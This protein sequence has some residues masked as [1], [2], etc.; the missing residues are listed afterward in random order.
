MSMAADFDK[1]SLVSVT[2]IVFSSPGW[3]LTA[4]AVNEFSACD[5]TAA[6]RN[7]NKEI[8]LF[9]TLLIHVIL[10]YQHSIRQVDCTITVEVCGSFKEF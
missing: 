8:I 6:S 5:T 3:M 10:E 7:T 2:A 9:I 1:S 4:S